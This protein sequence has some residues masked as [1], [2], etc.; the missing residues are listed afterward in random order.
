MS[1][2]NGGDSPRIEM[3]GVDLI[4]RE[5]S[6]QI[7]DEGYDAEH[8]DRYNRGDLA[9]IAATLA[10]DGTDAKVTDPHER[11]SGADPWS[12]LRKHGYEAGGDDI[13]KLTIAGA[14]IAA[15]IDRRLRRR[16]REGR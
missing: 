11:G 7:L 4:K 6:R 12:L 1:E 3:S 14:L 13:R 10:V 16:A 15:E 8:D 2:P 9:V 5:R